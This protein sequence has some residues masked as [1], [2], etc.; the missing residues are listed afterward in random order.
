MLSTDNWCI[1]VAERVYGPYTTSQMEDFAS[2]GRV[3]AQSLLAPAGG[4]VWREAHQYPNMAEILN[5]KRRPAAKARGKFGKHTGDAGKAELAEGQIANFILIF[6]VTS[7]AAGRLEHIVRNIGTAF[8]LCDNVWSV[9]S[10][11]SVMGIKN[12]IGPHLQI[13]E[14]IM[15]I[16][17]SRGRTAWQNFAPETHSKLTKAWTS[18]RAA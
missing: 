14:P 3:N 12:L 15:V 16:D 1:K 8:R 10:D 11:Q 2:E 13:R 4:K 18:I 5:G 17:T 9:S 6:D 7:G